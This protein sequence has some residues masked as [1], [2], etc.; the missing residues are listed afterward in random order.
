MSKALAL[1]ESQARA[2]IR[3]ARKEGARIEVVIGSTIIRLVPDDAE[4]Q[5]MDKREEIRL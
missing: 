3:A 2:L 1:P 5:A 4:K